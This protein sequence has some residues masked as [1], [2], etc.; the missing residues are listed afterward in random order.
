MNTKASECKGPEICVRKVKQ[1][2]ETYNCMLLNKL[3]IW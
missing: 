3:F 1:E 2:L